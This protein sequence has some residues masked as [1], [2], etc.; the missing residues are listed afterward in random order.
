MRVVPGIEELSDR[1]QMGEIG[2][3]DG[4]TWSLTPQVLNDSRAGST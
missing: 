1:P 2:G 4:M 3:S